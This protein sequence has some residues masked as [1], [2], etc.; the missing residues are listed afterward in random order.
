LT[1]L[2]LESRRSAV[3]VGDMSTSAPRAT[4]VRSP[5]FR[6]VVIAGV[7]AALVGG[8][9]YLYSQRHVYR[10]SVRPGEPAYVDVDVLMQR[11][12][13]SRSFAKERG[14]PVVCT[15]SG[16]ADGVRI[17]VIETGHSLQRLR[18]RLRVEARRETP[19]GRIRRAIDF[20]IDGQGDWPAA[21]LVVTVR[22]RAS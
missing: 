5:R 6:R 18:A 20:T 19:P 10:I 14:L 2:A 16:G 12:G 8:M 4:S 17:S 21:A 7:V 13:R 22:E 1:G 9:V 11:V 3:D 15:V